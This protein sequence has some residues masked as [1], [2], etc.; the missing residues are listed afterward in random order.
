MAL[1]SRVSQLCHGL[2]QNTFRGQRGR[3]LTAPHQE[4]LLE[5]PPHGQVQSHEAKVGITGPHTCCPRKDAHSGAG[6]GLSAHR[7]RNPVHLV[8]SVV[9]VPAPCLFC[10]FGHK[11]HTWTEAPHEFRKSEAGCTRTKCN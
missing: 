4:H 2:G 8:S 7:A 10:A 1:E 11:P 6:A 9:V 3:L 5:T